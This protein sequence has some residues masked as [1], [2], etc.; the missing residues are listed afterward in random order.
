MQGFRGTHIH[1]LRTNA[2]LIFGS[3][4]RQE[5]FMSKYDRE[6]NKTLQGL[7]GAHMSKEGKKYKF[8]API[9]FP[10]YDTSR[11]DELFLNP[12]FARVSSCF[13]RYFYGLLISLRL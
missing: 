6:S 1:R 7:L 8:L 10:E 9:F 12:A 13:I 5:W 3:E 4:F 11:T 2:S